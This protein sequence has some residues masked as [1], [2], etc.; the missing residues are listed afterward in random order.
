MGARTKLERGSRE[1]SMKARVGRVL[2]AFCIG[3]ILLALSSCGGGGGGGGGG[4]NLTISVSANPTTLQ[5]GQTAQLGSTVMHAG[6]CPTG[7]EGLLNGQYAFLLRGGGSPRL[8][9]MIGSFSADGSGNITGGLEDLND[10]ASAPQTDLA[11]TSPASLYSVGVDKRGCLALVTSQVT[12]LFRFAL[13]SVSGGVAAKGRIIEFDDAT[14]DGRRAEGFLVKQD[15]SSFATSHFQGKYAF[16][17]SGPDATNNRFVSAGVIQA[18]SGSLTSGNMDTN[19]VG[20]VTSNVTGVTGVTVCLGVAA[21]PWLSMLAGVR[22]LCCTW[23]LTLTS[24]PCQA[25]LSVCRIR[26]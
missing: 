21:G 10:T 3:V 5:A 2:A 25:T 13:S 18:G 1:A 24:L 19:D 9:A 11:V 20:T 7:N 6:D 26:C 16:G 17:L 12:I 4:A 15:R 22:I 8:V 14:G 23:F